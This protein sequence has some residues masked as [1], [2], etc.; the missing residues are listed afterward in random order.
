[1]SRFK[2][3]Q[4]EF[5]Q[6]AG[7]AD[8]DPWAKARAAELREEMRR[9][10]REISGEPPRMRAAAIEVKSGFAHDILPGRAVFADSFKAVR[11]LLVGGDGISV[12]E[13][14]IRPATHW[15]QP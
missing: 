14:L 2:T 5:I 8:F 3:A 4:Q 9:A 12:E 1:V 6:V 15:V 13:F 10:S 7:I 11:A